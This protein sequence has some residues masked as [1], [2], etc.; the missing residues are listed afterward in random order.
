MITYIIITILLLIS[1]FA[2]GKM[3]M[4]A[5][6]A[7][8]SNWWNKSDSWINKYATKLVSNHRKGF[9]H[10]YYFGF[11]Y[12][13]Y[14]ERFMYS[15]TIFVFLT[16]GWHFL[17]FIFLN[18]LTIALAISIGTDTLTILLAALYIELIYAVAFNLSYK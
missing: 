4:S 15:T 18:T 5:K 11:Y 17:Q 6:N 2:K 13:K 16:D 12:P 8:K 9:K 1:F 10:W 7:F 14:Q 3:D